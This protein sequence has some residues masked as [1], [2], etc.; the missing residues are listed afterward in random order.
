VA[1][2]WQ[3]IAGTGPFVTLPALFS[4]HLAKLPDGIYRDVHFEEYQKDPN[5]ISQDILP[6]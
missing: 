6:L 3:G 2:G 5:L 4:P 1:K